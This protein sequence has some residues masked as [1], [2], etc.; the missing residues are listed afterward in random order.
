MRGGAVGVQHAGVWQGKVSHQGHCLSFQ[1]GNKECMPV[2]HPPVQPM[3][4][5][6]EGV[7]Y[8]GGA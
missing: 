3:K 4:R 8:L 1:E 5:F 7:T 2:L 6:S